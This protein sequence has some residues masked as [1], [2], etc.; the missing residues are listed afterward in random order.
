MVGSSDG[1]ILLAV[2]VVAFVEVDVLRAVVRV[3]RAAA[4]TSLT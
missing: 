1:V 2:E 4:R 3:A